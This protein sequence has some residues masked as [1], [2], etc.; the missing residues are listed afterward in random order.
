MSPA[1]MIWN[2]AALD[3]GGAS[4]RRGDAALAA[5]LLVHGMVMNGGLGHVF[6]ALSAEE[7]DRGSDGFE[8]FGFSSIR[9]L[10][11]EARGMNEEQREGATVRYWEAVPNDGALTAAFEHTLR[12]HSAAFAPV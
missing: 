12:E 4:P 7:I 5:L 10:L 1:S 8:F 11:E 3:G 9:E 2:R 6:E